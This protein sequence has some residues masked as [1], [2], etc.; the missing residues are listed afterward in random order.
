MNSRMFY[1]AMSAYIFSLVVP[2]ENGGFCKIE[3]L[4]L[5]V[6]SNGLKVLV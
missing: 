4:L 5:I 2:A 6:H 3:E 1:S